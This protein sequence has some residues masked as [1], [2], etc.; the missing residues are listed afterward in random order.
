ML[1]LLAYVTYHTTRAVYIRLTEHNVSHGSH[2]SN[3]T[4]TSNPQAFQRVKP[5]ER[6]VQLDDRFK[7][8]L[9][10]PRFQV[11][12]CKCY[13]RKGMRRKVTQLESQFRTEASAVPVF[14]HDL[15]PGVRGVCRLRRGGWGS[16]SG[17]LRCGA[18][19]L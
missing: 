12:A 4:Y 1:A 15:E 7:A 11:S 6:K 8:V 18:I 10:D 13:G 9:T 16:E 19:A 2:R 14:R 17:R 3:P 5:D